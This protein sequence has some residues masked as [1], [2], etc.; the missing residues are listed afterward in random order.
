MDAKIALCPNGL[1]PETFRLYEAVRSGCAVISHTL[2][3]TRLFQDS[4]IQQLVSWDDDEL[5]QTICDLLANIDVESAN[6]LQ[7]WKDRYAP[8]AVANYIRNNL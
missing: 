3:Q 1:V 5:V 8:E 6:S 7:L 4:P 2:P